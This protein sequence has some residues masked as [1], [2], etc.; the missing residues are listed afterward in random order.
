MCTLIRLVTFLFLVLSASQLGIH[1]RIASVRLSKTVLDSTPWI[2]D[3][4]YWI[5]VFVSGPWI[6]DSNRLWYSRLLERYSG[7]QNPGFRIPEV[8]FSRIPD[9]SGKN[10]LDFKT[11]SRLPYMGRTAMSRFFV[12]LIKTQ[13]STL[14]SKKTLG[15]MV[16]FYLKL[17]FY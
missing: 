17:I 8:K 13:K 1:Y 10:F 9:S 5:P 11:E 14:Q 16:Q 6:S 4:R 7:F 15:I 12:T 3:S 2:P